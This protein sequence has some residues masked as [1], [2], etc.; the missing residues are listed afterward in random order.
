MKAQDIVVE[1]KTQIENA[2]NPLPPEGP[3][4][5]AEWEDGKLTE[6]GS[7]SS[8]GIAA[9][10]TF[11]AM[12]L[13]PGDLRL[14]AACVGGSYGSKHIVGNNQIMFYSAALA[15]VTRRPVAMFFNREE[16]LAAYQIRVPGRA[17]YKIGM[18]KDGTVT[19]R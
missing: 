15:K 19:K 3:G 18:K 9:A 16:H 8:T 17:R 6:W 7:F 10:R 4:V 14:I 11:R 12:K 2:Q 5:I 1:G 13:E